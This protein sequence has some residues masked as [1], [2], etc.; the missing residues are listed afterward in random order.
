MT[1]PASTANKVN[2]AIEEPNVAKTKLNPKAKEF[3][4]HIYSFIPQPVCESLDFQH[5]VA[6]GHYPWVPQTNHFLS[7]TPVHSFGNTVQFT[8]KRKP[9]VS[10]KPLGINA[11]IGNSF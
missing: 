11:A 10:D 5:P 3:Q 1:Q 8:T 2:I 4:P 7:S 6:P 9:I